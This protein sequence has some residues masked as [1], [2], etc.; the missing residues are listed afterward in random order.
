[1]NRKAPCS[2]GAVGSRIAMVTFLL[3]AVSS[4]EHLKAADYWSLTGPMSTARWKHTATLLTDGRVLITGGQDSANTALATA[5][6]YD[7]ALDDWSLTQ[8]MSTP[9]NGHTA[10][11]SEENTS[12]HQSPCHHV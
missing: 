10:T 4:V 5:E 12:E 6:I 7:P 2:F 3:W 11:R 8:S 9:R 1:M